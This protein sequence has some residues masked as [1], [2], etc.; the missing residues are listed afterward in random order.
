MCFSVAFFAP[1]TLAE[2]T[3]VWEVVCSTTGLIVL[4]ELH[5]TCREDGCRKEISDDKCKDDNHP[6]RIDKGEDHCRKEEVKEDKG[7][8]K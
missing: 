8:H 4:V 5:Y 6:R 1:N 3:A 2:R 7:S